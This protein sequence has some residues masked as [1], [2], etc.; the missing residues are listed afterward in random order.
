LAGYRPR[1]S[2][3]L[4]TIHGVCLTALPGSL[5]RRNGEM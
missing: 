2:R 4:P 3:L 5:G 1:S